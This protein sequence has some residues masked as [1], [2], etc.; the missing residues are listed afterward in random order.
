MSKEKLII[1]FTVLIDVIGIGIVVPILPFYVKSFG[2]SP[3]VITFLFSTF[4]FCA[5]FS[6]S[7]LGS[8][9]DKI[10]R[11]PVL[12]VSILSTSLGWFIFSFAPG[13]I[14]LFLGRIVDGLAA[15]NFSTAQ[16]CF[17]DLSKSGKER[18]ASFGF[19][20]AIFGIGFI[21]GPM[22]GG[23]LAGFSHKAPFIFVGLLAFLNFLLAVAFL[24]ET[25]K[26]KQ[27][28]KKI[29]FNPFSPFR[30]SFKKKPLR[31]IF[32]VWFLF[33]LTM[34]TT[35]AVLSL[36]LA[37][38]FHWT[39]SQV[40]FLIVGFG[41]VIAFNQGILLKR[42]WLKR[43][44][45]PGLALGMFAVSCFCYLLMTRSILGIFIMALL[46]AAFSESVLRAVITSLAVGL[47][48]EE[49]QGETLGVLSSIIS[50]AMITGP[51]VSGFLFQV[52]SNL[53][54]FFSAFYGFLALLIMA[55][56][57]KIIKNRRE[58]SEDILVQPPI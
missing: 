27:K 16:S 21:V 39:A 12:L 4:S 31:S 42:F 19:L 36:Y 7:F 24:P 6:T 22:L 9:S 37:K 44:S 58:F 57:V 35:Q 18:T 5:F 54:F 51:L 20:G 2:A 52:K 28:D 48:R 8:L 15:G 33:G 30:N 40:S 25:L 41:I 38:I 3:W 23:L 53:P 26:K 56:S 46:A 49:R 50:L 10:G 13:I 45:E 1:L 47:S 32:L 14:F 43:F 29:N 17:A 34:A 11:R 55:Y